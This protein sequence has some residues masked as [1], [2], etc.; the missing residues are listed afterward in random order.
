MNL[1]F[2]I[3]RRY[4]FSKK[5]HNAINIISMVSV[6]GVVVATTALVCALS[7]FNGF[8]NIVASMFSNFDPI[9]KITPR[10]GKVL[11]PTNARL[12]KVKQIPE[13]SIFCEVLQ[14]NAL[15]RYRDR[16]TVATVKGVDNNFRYLARIDSVIIDGRFMLTDSIANYAT[17]G[18]GLAVQL[19][20]RANFMD[21]IEIY[22]PKRDEK[23]NLA[24]PATAFNVEYTFA[25]AVYATNQQ[26]YDEDFM[27]IPLDVARSLFHYEKEASAIELGLHKS[28]NISRTEAKI[29]SILGDKY[30]VKNR[31]EQQDASY[32]MMPGEIWVTFLI[33]CFIL[34]LSLFNVIGSLSMLMIE[35]K[36]DVRTLRNMGASNR[37]IR[38]IF[39]YEGWMISG[40]GAVIGIVLGLILCV[41]QQQYG[42]LKLGEVSGTFI[43]DAYP[44]HV[45]AADII[46]IFVTV[47]AIGF[48]A[49]WYPVHFL[50]KKWF[51]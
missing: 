10:Y 35:K 33:L 26:V 50:G 49:A 12:Q 29:K 34:G 19:G 11:D 39:L 7:V 37:L 2:H 48:L 25:K 24:N 45:E 43:I 20:L 51:K 13:V 4:L 47:V 15:V 5:S 18:A 44:V 36:D 17:L 41:L 42:L 28:A 46:T 6:C 27:I 31:Y 1:S 23:V 8:T 14:D 40:F 30:W 16:Q 32:K 38:R 3:A 21:P 9:L 22:V